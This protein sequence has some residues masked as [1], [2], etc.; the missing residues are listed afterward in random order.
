MNGGRTMYS[1]VKLQVKLT[2]TK[3]YKQYFDFIKVQIAGNLDFKRMFRHMD[4]VA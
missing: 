1:F 4:M 2:E 3:I